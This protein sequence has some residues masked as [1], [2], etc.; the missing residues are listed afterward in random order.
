MRIEFAVLLQC[1]LLLCS[2]SVSAVNI[3]MVT[4]GNPGNA[5]DMRYNLDKRPE[6]F[7]A[8]N[9]DYQIGKYEI[10]QGQYTEFLNAVAKDD[11]N[12][13]YSTYMLYLDNQVDP[14]FIKRSGTSPNYNYSV[15]SAWANDATSFIGWYDAIRFC[16]WLHNGQPTG[17]QGPETTEDGA[18]HVIGNSSLG[19]NANAKFFLPTEDEWYKAAYHDKAAGVSASYF[20]YPT[21][22]NVVPGRDPTETTNPGNNAN[23]RDVVTGSYLRTQVGEFELS[24]SPYGT[25]DQGG[26][27][28]EWVESW[29]IRST[30]PGLPGL[31]GGSYSTNS[32]SLLAAYRDRNKPTNRFETGFRIAAAAPVPEP[33]CLALFS[34]AAMMLGSRFRMRQA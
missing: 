15:A 21:G 9:Y 5:P 12:Q 10:T 1:I 33:T 3:E 29:V 6:G 28:P 25:F 17:P 8:V 14:K 13:L 34:I 22:T 24:A 31:R 23:Y 19:R 2:Q 20:D 18:Y 11:P 32:D 26:N 16:N 4:V 7:G 27:M 30:S